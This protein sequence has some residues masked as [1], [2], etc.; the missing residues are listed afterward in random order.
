[1]AVKQRLDTPTNNF[2]TLN[3]LFINGTETTNATSS[4]SLS[5][6]NLKLTADSNYSLA[7]GTFTMRTGKWYWETYINT[8]VNFPMTGITHGTS[9]AENS[10]VGYDPNG[11]VKGISYS[12]DGTFYGDSNGDGTHAANN[13]ATGLSTYT[14]GDIIGCFFDADIGSLKF[15]KNGTLIRTESGINRHDW[16]PATSAYNSGINTVNFGQDA[17]FV[18]NKTPTKVYTDARGL[19]RFYYQPPEGAL[20]LCTANLGASSYKSAPTSY[21]SDE[22][23]TKILTYNGNVEQVPYSPYATDGYSMHGIA[24]TG[25]SFGS[26]SDF[27]YLHDNT[28]Q[29]YSISCWVYRT[30]G[31][32]AQALVD[33]CN[34]TSGGHGV[35]FSIEANNKVF[36]QINKGSG[37]NAVAATGS[38]E[39]LPLNKWTH[40]SVLHNGTITS[41]NNVVS[42][43]IN[44]VEVTYSTR[45]YDHTNS[46]NNSSTSLHVGIRSGVN[47]GFTG[48]IADLAIMKNVTS[49]NFVAQ[50][51]KITSSTH[52]D[53]DFLLSV[54]SIGFKDSSSSPKTVTTVGTPS[55]EAWSP[56]TTDAIEF[57]TE[58]RT[59]ETAH[60]IGSFDFTTSGDK[61]F[62]IKPSADFV[63]DTNDFTIEFWLYQIS[64]TYTMYWNRGRGSGQRD[65]TMAYESVAA[66]KF[67]Y[68]TYNGSTQVTTLTSNTDLPL[69]SW[70]HIAIVYDHDHPSKKHILYQNGLEVA[71]SDTV[72]D[73]TIT[74]Y[75]ATGS[76]PT[77]SSLTNPNIRWG[78]AETS[79]YY[80]YFKMTDLRVVKGVA[81]YTG[82]FTPPISELSTTQSSGSGK[83]TVSASDTKLLLQPYKSY[84]ADNLLTSNFSFD[85]DTSTKRNKV[86]LDDEHSSVGPSKIKIVDESP[87]KSGGNGSFLL[88]NN[89]DRISVGPNSDLDLGSDPFTIEMWLKPSTTTGDGTER[90]LVSKWSSGNAFR[91]SYDANASSGS[92][93]VYTGTTA[94]ATFTSAL[95]PI[96]NWTH[97]ALVRGHENISTIKLYYNGNLISSQTLGIGTGAFGTGNAAD[98]FEIGNVTQ[99]NDKGYFGL[100]TDFRYAKTAVYVGNFNPPYAPLTTT[101]GTYASS[102]NI[103]NPSSAQTVLFLQPGALASNDPAKKPFKHF[104]PVKYVGTEADGNTVT[105]V[106]FKS[107]LIWIKDRDSSSQH[108]WIDSVRGHNKEIFSSLTNA[109]TTDANR[110]GSYKSAL[111]VINTDGFVLN[112]NVGPTGS[113]NVVNKKHIAWCWKAGGSTPSK[114]Y[115]VKVSGGKYQFFGDVSNSGGP[116][117]APTLSLQ[118]GGTYTFDQS[119]SSNG[120]SNTHPLRFATAADAAGS[121]QY[122]T[123]V[124]YSGTPGT[125]GAYVRITVAASAPTLYYY[126]TNHSGMG[127]QI[128]TTTTHG[129]TEFGG[130]IIPIV[131]ANKEAGFS[132][133]KYTGTNV[134]STMGHGLS[135]AP[136]V[137][138]LKNLDSADQWV[139]YHKSVASD[140]ETDYLVLNTTAAAVDA[141]IWNDTAPTNQVFSI[142]TGG[143]VS[144]PSE[145]FIAYCWHSVPGYSSIGSYE[146]NANADGPFI[147]TGFRPAWFMVK[148]ADDGTTSSGPSW[149]IYDSAREPNNDGAF[150]SL[151]ANSSGTEGHRPLDFLSNGIKIREPSSW[152]L[153]AA[154][155][156]IYIAFAEAP[157]NFSNAR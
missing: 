25:L 118:E 149:D 126:C 107:D 50:S 147:Y 1:M 36:F 12:G 38:N 46:S 51:S 17:T 37:G 73:I 120:L 33:T 115:Y 44:G 123:N 145:N 89:R 40:I 71:S 138:L 15:F 58:Y 55:I 139:V 125:D 6:G 32:V 43:Y 57:G 30:A 140:A 67:S 152:N 79:T 52:A 155:T 99:D 8:S 86:M 54:D 88:S 78:K 63:W 135:K 100:I 27:K 96:G 72:S 76:G 116:A 105:G 45:T 104:K 22:T 131:S 134:S 85:G 146:G 61:Y 26:V 150:N 14:T 141:T 92:I 101:G 109:E 113:T 42:M 5:E 56:Y 59:P 87:Y 97:F 68:I 18:G 133:A 83:A 103:S 19:G 91:I 49:S 129:Q 11:N 98:K 127:G 82:N 29:S 35:S 111:S 132:I 7:N 24:T 122:T 108:V 64:D 151:S 2:A 41:G 31:D 95:L 70:N 13:T 77:G 136:E 106:G 53:I 90:F 20:A 69:N 128:N 94:T 47:L 143:S 110:G 34:F 80:P 130:S 157:V 144:E 74:N 84:D 28:D 156:Y 16:H 75:G 117:N 66:N 137:I 114:T 102:T 81:A 39:T 4:L 65:E 153:N 48:Y 142:G 9:T 112:S 148:N 23:N 154:N 93:I 62:Y 60:E 3:P 119:D 124:S 10:Y 21:V 121:T